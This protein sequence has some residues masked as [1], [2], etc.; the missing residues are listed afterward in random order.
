VLVLAVDGD[1]DSAVLAALDALVFYEKNRTVLASHFK[2]VRIRESGGPLVALV[3]RQFSD[4]L[5]ARLRGLNQEFLRLLELRSVSSARGERTYLVPIVPGAPSQGGGEAR[6]VAPLTELLTPAQR[7]LAEMLLRRIGRID[8]QLISASGDRS[9]SWRLGEEIVC[10]LLAIDGRLEGQVPPA[11]KPRPIQSMAD[12]E[13]FVDEV[14]ERYVEL[15]GDAEH[16][17]GGDL[18]NPMDAPDQGVLLTP[19]EIAA[20]RQPG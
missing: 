4:R 9:L 11:G 1:G 17:H 18:P 12:V 5:L 15:L 3:A 2:S 13:S 8:E 6:N 20:F 7:E 19:E 16:R 14:L 10:C